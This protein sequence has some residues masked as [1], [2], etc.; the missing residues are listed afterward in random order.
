M[1]LGLA[2]EFVPKV[3]WH[4]P[5]GT[6]AT[7]QA[8]FLHPWILLVTIIPG[9]VGTAVLLFIP[10][11]KILGLLEHLGAGDSLGAVGLTAEFVLKVNRHRQEGPTQLSYCLCLCFLS[12]PKS[13]GVKVT[14]C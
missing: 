4:R 1:L 12:L 13:Q 3:S 2:A 6:Q 7:G 10:D 8:G 5:E 9:G 14:G 11:P